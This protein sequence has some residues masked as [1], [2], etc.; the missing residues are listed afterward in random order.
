MD[1]RVVWRELHGRRFQNVLF[2]SNKRNTLR[3][4]NRSFCSLIE[5]SPQ[6]SNSGARNSEWWNS[7]LISRLTAMWLEAPFSQELLKSLEATVGCKLSPKQ[8]VG[9]IFNRQ[10]SQCRIRYVYCIW[11][12]EGEK[13]EQKANK[14]GLYRKMSTLN[15]SL[16]LVEI[17]CWG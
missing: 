10:L 9:K 16:F 2:T 11:H 15:N 8:N 4:C 6:I 12:A 3:F 7:Q 14:I 17:K 1:C 13:K 5:R